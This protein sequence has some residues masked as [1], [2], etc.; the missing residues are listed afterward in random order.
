M[1]VGLFG[2]T[3]VLYLSLVH[4]A[5]KLDPISL[6][7]IHH[8]AVSD[9]LVSLIMFLPML[10]VLCARRWVLGKVLCFGSAFLFSVP[11]IYEVLTILSLTGMIVV[12]NYAAANE[13]K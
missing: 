6:M 9:I 13:M 11:L 10:I 3:T 12:N 5:L 1:I 8:L 2:N 7:F 4:N